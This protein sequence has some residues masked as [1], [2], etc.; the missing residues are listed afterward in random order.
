MYFVAR[1][2]A[3]LKHK[4]IVFFTLYARMFHLAA[5][6]V[7]EKVNS[8]KSGSTA[9]LKLKGFAKKVHFMRNFL[10]FGAAL[11]VWQGSTLLYESK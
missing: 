9:E 6:A 1:C 7:K 10:L 8:G 3:K 2:Y 11:L 4:H 5:V